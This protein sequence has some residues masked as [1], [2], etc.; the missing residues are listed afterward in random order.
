M[1]CSG[2]LPWSA[3][4]LSQPDILQDPRSSSWLCLRATLAP[5]SRVALSVPRLALGCSEPAHLGLTQG[6][7]LGAERQG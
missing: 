6:A 3:I 5:L 1:P 7:T 4:S 2:A